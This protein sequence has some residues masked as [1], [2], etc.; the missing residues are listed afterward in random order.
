M[1]NSIVVM[2][3]MLFGNMSM[4]QEKLYLIFEF[5]KVDNE[6]E[7]AYSEAEAFWEKIQEQR[8]KAGDII[9]WDLWS[10]KPGGEM[11][12]F[13]YVTVSLYRD[14]VKMMDG[15]S[16]SNLADRAKAAYPDMTEA[17]LMAKVQGSS[18]TRDLAVRIYAEEI[19]TTTGSSAAEMVLGTVAQIDMMKVAF[20]NYTA[21]EKAE[22]EVFQPMH[23]SA[24]DA[25]GKSSWGLI[26]IL[27]PVGSDTYASHMTVN[28]FKDYSQM[29]NQNID[30]N[31]GVTPEQSKAMQEGM[32]SRDM[33]YVYIAELIKM[34]R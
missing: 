25:G 23:Q 9:G 29:I 31:E 3:L 30:Y 20:E 10:L 4:A 2:A 24:V 34:A 33:K 1:K 19:A 6:Q 8:V 14:P 26:R 32:A 12:D 11:Q 15:S 22:T 17:D 16:W 18:K 27:S 13:Q 21:Y 5:M 28:M 7:A